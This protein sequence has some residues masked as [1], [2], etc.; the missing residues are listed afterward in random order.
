MSTTR[1]GHL[2]CSLTLHDLARVKKVPQIL[3]RVKKVLKNARGMNA[4]NAELCTHALHTRL[5]IQCLLFAITR[6]HSRRLSEKNG[7][8]AQV[9]ISG[10][11]G[12]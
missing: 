12:T 7:S 2:I 6:E 3:T 5:H 8:H 1:H 4:L 10:G 9:V 11:S